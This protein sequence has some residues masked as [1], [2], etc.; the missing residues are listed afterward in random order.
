MTNEEFKELK[1]LLLEAPSG[2]LDKVA[3]DSIREWDDTDPKAIQILKTLDMCVHSGLSSGFVVGVL[4]QMLYYYSTK[5]KI[6]Y[7]E[8]TKQASWR[9]DE[10][11][12]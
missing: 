7:E 11:E 12:T 5:E 6:T 8:L 4:E 3:L 2:H 1:D 10:R 9:N